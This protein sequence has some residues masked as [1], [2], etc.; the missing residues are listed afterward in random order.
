MAA[1]V[2]PI[3]DTIRVPIV[4]TERWQQTAIAGA[5]VQSLLAMLVAVLA[6][7]VGGQ[8]PPIDVHAAPAALRYER[9]VDVICRK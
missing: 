3:G 1:A 5:A 9:I 6:M 8:L 7:L 2:A 4:S